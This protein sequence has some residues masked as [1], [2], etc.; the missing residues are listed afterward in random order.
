MINGNLIT[1]SLWDTAGSSEYDDIRYYTY[2]NTSVF[3]IL[4][5]LE[6]KKSLENVESKWIKEIRKH[7]DSQGI[8][9]F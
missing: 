1:F 5:S 9:Q 3:L 7:S 8:K 2:P 4:F 6:D